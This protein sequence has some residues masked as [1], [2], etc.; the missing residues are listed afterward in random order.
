MANE[1]DTSLRGPGSPHGHSRGRSSELLSPGSVQQFT[2]SLAGGVATHQSPASRLFGR[3]A[4]EDLHALRPSIVLFPLCFVNPKDE[5]RFYTRIN[6][7]FRIR[8][9][10]AAA[11]SFSLFSLYWVITAVCIA[12]NTFPTAGSPIDVAFS[13]VMAATIFLSVIPYVASTLDA[14]K[15]HIETSLYVSVILVRPAR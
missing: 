6:Q 3:F 11:A 8:A 14:L 4:S 15:G 9:R 12:R 2:D 10:I 5:R 1:R 7:T 13:V